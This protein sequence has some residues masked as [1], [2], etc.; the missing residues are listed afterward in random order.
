M[1][2]WV[3]EEGKGDIYTVLDR[4]SLAWRLEAKY[5]AGFMGWLMG[6]V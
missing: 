5:A 2:K 1:M 6:R 3:I 4:W